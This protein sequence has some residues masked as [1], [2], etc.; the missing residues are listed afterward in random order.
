MESTSG[1]AELE[2]LRGDS[3]E[4]A[5][6]RDVDPREQVGVLLDWTSLVCANGLGGVQAGRWPRE[7]GPCG[8]HVGP[9]PCVCAYGQVCEARLPG[10]SGFPPVRSSFVT[11]GVRVDQAGAKLCR[12]S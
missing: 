3:G 9:R 6:G 4:A 11:R 7:S 5:L 2:F 10:V 8:G 12:C 1:A